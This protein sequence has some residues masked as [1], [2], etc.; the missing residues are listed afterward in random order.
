MQA[1]SFLMKKI[2][3]SML[4]SMR[5]LWTALQELVLYKKH[6]ISN[7]RFAKVFALPLSVLSMQANLHFLTHYSTKNAQLSPILQELRETASKQV[8]IRMVTIGLLLIPQDC[9]KHMIL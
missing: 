9:E 1:L 2:W 5:L 3:N 8:F 6:L 4:T 7:N